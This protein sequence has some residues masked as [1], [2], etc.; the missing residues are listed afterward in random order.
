MEDLIA[1]FGKLNIHAYGSEQVQKHEAH[2]ARFLSRE[3]EAVLN[4]PTTLDQLGLS[5]TSGPMWEETGNLMETH[6]DEKFEFFDSFLDSRYYAYTM[7]YYGDTP[8]EIHASSISLEVAQK[9]K[10]RLICERIGLEGEERILNLGC[11]F[12]SFER[13]LKEYYP[14]TQ[15]VGVTPSKVQVAA[16]QECLSSPDSAFEGLDFSVILKDV[17]ALTDEDIAPE[18]FD[19]IS[20]I[21]LLEQ[22]KNM[23]SF[24]TKIARYLKPGGKAFHHMISSRI[25]IPQF[26]NPAETL[27]GDYFPGGR[28]WPMDELPK[29]TREF[30]HKQSWFLN[31]MNYWMT[32]DEWHRR[33]WQNMET[34]H[35]HLSVERI[36]FWNDYFILCKACFSPM[37]G[38]VFGNAHHLFR[39]PL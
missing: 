13:Y 35:K 36:R 20:S 33:F 6:Y 37:S 16:I 22:S 29:H 3:Y 23:Q 5:T 7:A 10:F 26:I 17:A 25:T 9:N 39:K 28:I 21:G 19:V 11:G 14:N 34:L 24:Q 1:K 4:N 32:L 15:V 31:G 8:E 27:I 2:I 12:G 18:S 38:E 30:E